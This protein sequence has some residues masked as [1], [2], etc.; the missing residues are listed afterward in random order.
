VKR[1]PQKHAAT[2]Q[3]LVWARPSR[4][5]RAQPPLSRSQIVK[6]A[7][8]IADRDG[9]EAVTMRRIAADLG[10]GTTS[11]YWHVRS[12]E[13]LFELMFDAFIGEDVIP[14]RLSGD[15]RQELRTIAMEG[16]TAMVRH[17]WVPDLGIQLGFGPAS[18]RY[19]AYA[20]SVLDNLGLDDQTVVTILS[21]L[22]NYIMGFAHND[23]AVGRRKAGWRG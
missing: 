15:W 7:I 5:V 20:T 9:L 8:G 18:L 1:Q 3:L 11:L 16:R 19:Y 2:G 10:A 13:E 17:P 14:E 12:K 6:A 23:A 22:V 4:P 21:V